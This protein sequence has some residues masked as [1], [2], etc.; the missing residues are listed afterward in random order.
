MDAPVVK[1][2][3]KSATTD[4][5]KLSRCFARLLVSIPIT[6]MRRWRQS[7]WKA[8]VAPEPQ[9]GQMI[10]RFVQKLPNCVKVKQCSLEEECATITLQSRM[11]NKQGNP[12]NENRM[13][14]I[15]TGISLWELEH[16]EIL[17]LNTNSPFRWYTN[18]GYTLVYI[19][20]YLIMLA[21]TKDVFRGN[22]SFLSWML[23]PPGF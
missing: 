13:P 5:G 11:W 3:C 22:D 7:C 20:W 15:K 1:N 6:K 14:V 16:R 19:P 18:V 23:A 21:S 17:S 8:Q 9:I 2:W 4:V 10:A 12:R